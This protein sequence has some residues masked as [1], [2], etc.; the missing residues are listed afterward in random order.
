MER[1]R[2]SVLVEIVLAL[3]VLAAT[4]V[5]VAEPRGKEAVAT[6]E[7]RP[8]STTGDLGDGRSVTVTVT[9]GRHG[10]VAADV[11]LSSGAQP[12][13]MTATAALPAKQLG[14]IP[15][16][17]TANGTRVYAASGINLPVAGD[18]LITVVVTDSAFNA[19]AEQVKIHL[20]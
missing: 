1:L 8:A 4:S 18:W 10:T 5:L 12:Q 13:K 19:T 3:G 6:R 17:L 2:R 16:P 20:Y 9:P 15:I 14:P 7:L 11:V